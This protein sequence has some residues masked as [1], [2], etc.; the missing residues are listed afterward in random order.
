MRLI[1]LGERMSLG[2]V[3]L[4]GL[5]LIALRILSAFLENPFLL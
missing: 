4:V 3:F 2:R 1:S 5:T